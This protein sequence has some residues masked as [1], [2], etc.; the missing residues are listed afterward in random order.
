MLKCLLNFLKLIIFITFLLIKEELRT[1]KV[2]C[3]L[4]AHGWNL[5]YFGLALLIEMIPSWKFWPISYL[6]LTIFALLYACNV[7]SLM[8]GCQFD[9]QILALQ[10]IWVRSS[11]PTACYFVVLFLSLIFQFNFVVWKCVIL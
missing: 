3:Q 1:K 2:T 5:L 9:F 8:S 10:C 11:A 7:G 6:I 4:K